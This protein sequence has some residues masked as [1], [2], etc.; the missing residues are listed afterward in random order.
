[1]CPLRSGR[2]LCY[3]IVRKEIKRNMRRT[4][5]AMMAVSAASGGYAAFERVD[6]LMPYSQ[7]AE[8]AFWSTSAHPAPTVSRSASTAQCVLLG[9]VAFNV[10]G[11]SGLEAQHRTSV[12]SNVTF[13]KRT[14]PRGVT[15]NFR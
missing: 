8:T 14:S 9:G 15:L 1:M 10:S 2:W 5:I 3:H 11:A 6:D 12:Q 13:V 7:S 4:L